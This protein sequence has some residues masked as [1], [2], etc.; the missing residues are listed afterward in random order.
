MN[1]CDYRAE[2]ERIM[3]RRHINGNLNMEAMFE[4]YISGIEP[5]TYIEKNRLN[6]N[7]ADD[8]FNRYLVNIVKLVK[9]YGYNVVKMP[10][11]LNEDLK[12]FYND[13]Y[14]ISECVSYITEKLD[15]NTVQVKRT[16]KID[17]ILLYNKLLYVMHDIPDAAL[18]DVEDKSETTYAVVRIKLFDLRNELNTDIKSYLAGIHKNFSAYIKQ[19]VDNASRIEIRGYSANQKSVYCTVSIKLDFVEDEHGEETLSMKETANTINMYVNI[20][21]MFGEQYRNLI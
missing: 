20:F 9:K 3:S 5:R 8:G 17:D 11:E 7:R 4:A 1:F 14:G 15:K 2:I 19:N 13:G 21:K 16:G 18:I 10:K 6:E 12:N